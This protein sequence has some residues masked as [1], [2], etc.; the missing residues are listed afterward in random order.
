M[1]VLR[2]EG[3]HEQFHHGHDPARSEKDAPTQPDADGSEDCEYDGGE[4]RGENADT[5]LYL[6]Y[7][8]DDQR[9]EQA[10]PADESMW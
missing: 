9:A 6:D 4:G 10:D 8:G 3:E 5:A 2:G 7:A 1:L